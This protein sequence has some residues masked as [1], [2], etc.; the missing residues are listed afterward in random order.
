M[1]PNAP[2]HRPDNSGAERRCWTVRW[3]RLFGGRRRLPSF[4]L[5][6]PAGNPVF[7][8]TSRVE[9]RSYSLLTQPVCAKS[10]VSANARRQQRDTDQLL[11]ILART[12]AIEPFVHLK[13]FGLSIEGYGHR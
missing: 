11:V 4:K 2:H 7:G 1:T 3:M 9:F 13:G 12:I 5:A 6:L 10:D 8:A